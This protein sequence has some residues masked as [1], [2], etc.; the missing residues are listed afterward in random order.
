MIEQDD[1]KNIKNVS[2]YDQFE[3][4]VLENFNAI[5][6][7]GKTEILV[8]VNQGDNGYHVAVVEVD[9]QELHNLSEAWAEEMQ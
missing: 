6:N 7:V 8:P 1:V 2:N 4:L 9:E 3:R 5:E